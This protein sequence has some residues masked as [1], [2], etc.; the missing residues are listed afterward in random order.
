M[1]KCQLNHSNDKF[2]DIISNDDC[3]MDW[4][5][6]DDE[7]F[8]IHREQS[9]IIAYDVQILTESCKGKVSWYPVKL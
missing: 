5:A 4:V 6:W 1:C 2:A 7:N 9:L 3:V 8:L